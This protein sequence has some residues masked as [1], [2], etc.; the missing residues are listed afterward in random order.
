MDGLSGMM[1][2]NDFVLPDGRRVSTGNKPLPR[3][4]GEG[5]TLEQAHNSN[6][7]VP[8]GSFSG[9]RDQDVADFFLAEARQN[10]VDGVV[11][12]DV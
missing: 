4:M 7:V 12:H 1:A 10:W 5:M 2:S 9:G 3:R 8:V 11:R 6:E